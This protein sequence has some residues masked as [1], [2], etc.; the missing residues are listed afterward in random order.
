MQP[1]ARELFELVRAEP[2]SETPRLILADWYDAQGDHRGELIRIQ[3]MLNR[4]RFDDPQRE[5]WLDRE[6]EL[7]ALY[8]K[9]WTEPLARLGI[10]CG[11]YR[12]LIEELTVSVPTFLEQARFFF[13]NYPIRRILFHDVNDQLGA[14]IQ[15]PELANLREMDLCNNFLGNA[16]PTLLSRCRFLEQLEYLNLSFNDLTDS[17]LKI[18]GDMRSLS[19]LKVLILSDNSHLGTPGIRAIA[20]S[21]VF[22][23]L[24]TLD[25]SGNDLPGTFVRVIVNADH[26]DSLQRL[27]FYGNRIGDSG[28]ASFANSRLMRS[29]LERTPIL[30]L[31]QCEIGPAGAQA[32]VETDSIL[33]LEK[34]DLTANRLGDAGLRVLTRASRLANLR[35]LLVGKNQITDRG[36]QSLLDSPLLDTL[37]EIDLRDNTV[38][39]EGCAEVQQASMARNR[40]EPL[41]I[42][43]NAT[44][45]N[46]RATLRRT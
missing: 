46:R 6:R 45:F 27:I 28:L 25:L 16:G 24:H 42:K 19:D 30:D 17:G 31:K 10:S 21:E 44:V 32:L 3:L 29:G 1:R 20:D 23:N 43:L 18:L 22:G 5:E 7:L 11:F 34:L 35:Y 41:Q 33:K 14:L 8:E 2:D 26:M 4:L 39:E 38:T 13:A 37:K 40:P 12:G 36:L 15:S 9:R